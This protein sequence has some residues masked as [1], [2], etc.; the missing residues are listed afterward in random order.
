VTLED[1]STE[2]VV[3]HRLV[4]LLNGVLVLLKVQLSVLIREDYRLIVLLVAKLVLSEL[5]AHVLNVGGHILLVSHELV[6]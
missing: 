1:G 4:L 2:R 6:N 3:L 5:L